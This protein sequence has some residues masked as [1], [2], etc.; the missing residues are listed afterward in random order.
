MEII[1]KIKT[2][3]LVKN[4]TEIQKI[5]LDKLQSSPLPNPKSEP[6]RLSNK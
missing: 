4:Q 2:N 6:W 5:C 1:E 3:K